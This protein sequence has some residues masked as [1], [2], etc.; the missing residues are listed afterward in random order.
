MQIDGSVATRVFYNAGL[1]SVAALNAR[2]GRSLSVEDAFYIHNGQLLPV[3]EVTR[4]TLRCIGMR[5]FETAG[6][7]AIFGDLF[8]I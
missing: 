2:A 5:S 7:S 1:F 4:R 8:R 6:K 3:P